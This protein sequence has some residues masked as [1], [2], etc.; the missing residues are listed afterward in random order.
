MAA[1]SKILPII[2]GFTAGSWKFGDTAGPN[3]I[4][5][6]RHDCHGFRGHVVLASCVNSEADAA[7]MAAAPDLYRIAH[8]QRALIE[9]LVAS[10][11]ESRTAMSYAHDESEEFRHAENRNACPCEMAAIFRRAG[12]AL[13]ASAPFLED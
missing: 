1:E 3:G 13:A 6:Y 7:L 4:R 2:E 11:K 10:L 8:E 12:E 9:K 5:V